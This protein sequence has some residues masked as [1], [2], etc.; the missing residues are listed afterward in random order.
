ME[1]K[2][3]LIINADDFGYSESVNNAVLSAF[4]NGILTSA[5]LMANAPA[6]D[7]AVSLLSEMRS[8]SVGVHLNIVEFSSLNFTKGKKSF[9]CNTNGLYNNGFVG[10]LIKSFDNNF[11]KEVETDFRFQIEKILEVTDVDH[12]DSHVHI[13]AIPSIFKIVVKLAREYNIPNIRTQF[14]YPY[15]VPDTEKY[16]SIKYPVNLVKVA[17]LNTFTLINKC[18]LKNIKDLKTNE[19]FIGVNYTGYM[20]TN[21][22]KCALKNVKTKT[23]AILHP[24]SDNIL[25]GRYNEFC[26]LVDEDLKQFIKNSDIELINFL[27]ESKDI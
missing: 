16:F 20:D 14:E 1:L 24:S 10:L 7:N 12:I 27:N 17:L 18:Y 5:S 15:F 19:N 6:F 23:E 3:Q 9:L 25:L 2:K 4:K 11:L 26:A 21:T 8:L 13:H 22:V